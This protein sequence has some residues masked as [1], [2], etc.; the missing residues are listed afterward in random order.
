LLGRDSEYGDKRRE[1]NGKKWKMKKRE[2]E[3]KK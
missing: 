3:L 2:Q 1:K